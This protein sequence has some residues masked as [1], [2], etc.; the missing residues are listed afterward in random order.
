[1]GSFWIRIFPAGTKSTFI[2][3]LSKLTAYAEEVLNYNHCGIA[4]NVT[5]KTQAR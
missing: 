2:E 3:A 1:M 4:G 5:D